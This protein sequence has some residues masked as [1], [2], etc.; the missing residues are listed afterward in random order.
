MTQ[1]SQAKSKAPSSDEALVHGSPHDHLFKNSFSDPSIVQYFL[2]V[3]L[4][5]SILADMDLSTL[6]KENNSFQC[7]YQNERHSDLVLSSTFRGRSQGI[8][9]II[10]HQST[11]D[12]NMQTRMLE[13]KRL[14]L[15]NW[16]QDP[17]NR[18]KK[19][20][21]VLC[22]CLYHGK[23]PYPY[24]ID[25]YD[26]FFYP[27]LEKI[28]H[29][30]MH[31]IDLKSQPDKKFLSYGPLSFILYLL[32]HSGSKNYLSAIKS[33]K[34][35]GLAK[36]LA[37]SPTQDYLSLIS[38][39]LYIVDKENSMESLLKELKEIPL[40][41]NTFMQHIQQV[42]SKWMERGREKGRK[43]GKKEGREEGREEGLFLGI[44]QGK[45]EGLFLG[46]E[47]GKK[48]EKL[49]IAQALRKQGVDIKVI[50]NAT[51]LLEKD[52]II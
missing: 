31:L 25:Y 46:L 45:K 4:S 26:Q 30:K 33:A 13:Y 27:D 19:Y 50:E 34:D 8:Y 38:I 41:Y 49:A 10:E 1:P 44:E 24:S 48:E 29:T 3:E 11:A 43:E 51:G 2:K 21:L 37:I 5:P 47:K 7:P 22:L 14:F 35:L 36:S 16:N 17:K 32:K 28:E 9:I 42:R 40:I 6:K 15:I 52:I 12:V 20:P 23:T 39:Y 18:V